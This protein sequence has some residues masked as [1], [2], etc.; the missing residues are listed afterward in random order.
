MRPVLLLNATYEPLTVTSTRRAV[1]LLLA[2]RA[3][4]I[5]ADQGGAL[6]RA[7]TLSLASPSVIRLRRVVQPP[8][9]LKVP[10]TRR[11][12]LVRDRYRCA[13][14]SQTANTIDHVVPRS[15]GGDH[16]WMNLVAACAPCNNRK[17]D[18]TLAELGWKLRHQPWTP[19]PR[20]WAAHLAVAE[21]DPSWGP[22]LPQLA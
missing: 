20:T 7:A 14:C 6:V 15:R 17:G 16:S 8:R 4:L 18:H 1:A 9:H 3:D 2:E 10:A 5:E 19:T 11:G 22:Y 12:V 13:Y 21:A